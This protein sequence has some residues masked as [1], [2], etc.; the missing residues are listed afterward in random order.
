MLPQQRLHVVLT[1][2]LGEPIDALLGRLTA[3][4]RQQAQIHRALRRRRHYVLGRLAARAAARHALG[5]PGSRAVEIL[6]GARGEPVVQVDGVAS[7]VS[8]TLAH[9]GRLAAAGAWRSRSGYAAGIDLERLRPTDVAESALVFSECERALLARAQVGGGQA[10]LATWAVKEATWKA[11]G[12]NQ[13]AGVAE[14]E[15]RA[16]DLDA[17]YAEVQVDEGFLARFEDAAVSAGVG[18]ID[19]PDECYILAVTTIASRSLEK[20]TGGPRFWAGDRIC[21]VRG[22]ACLDARQRAGRVGVERTAARWR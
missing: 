22:F 20:G 10:G 9:S 4:E 19:G 1:A 13:G 2:D 14:I 6:S 3:A 16:L 18:V 5:S 12:P 7:A 21:A 17:G 15:V 11:L 8:L